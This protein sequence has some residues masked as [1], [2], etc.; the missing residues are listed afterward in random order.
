MKNL[1]IIAM[2]LLGVVA[3]SDRKEEVQS[4]E[5]ATISWPHKPFQNYCF[6]CGEYS[7]DYRYACVN[8]GEPGESWNVYCMQVAMRKDQD[9]VHI[10]NNLHPGIPA[11]PDLDTNKA[12]TL[13]DSMLIHQIG[14]NYR[15]YYGYI[16]F[17][18]LESGGIPLLDMP[19]HY[20]FA[21]AT[22]AV[23]DSMYYGSPSCVPI[24]SGYKTDALGM[25]AYWRAKCD[26]PVFQASLDSI[27]ADLN[28]FTG[29]TLSQIYGHFD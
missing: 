2:L 4:P 20:D 16:G 3:C 8:Q 28:T 15:T 11:A 23:A 18:M 9:P 14:A 24:S 27:T 5:T 13:R 26:D 1:L 29:L 21:V 10:V 7:T 25:I 22:Y 6:P 19:E 12:A 17:C